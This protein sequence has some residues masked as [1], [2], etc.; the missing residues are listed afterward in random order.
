MT[1]SICPWIFGESFVTKFF[2]FIVF[3]AFPFREDHNDNDSF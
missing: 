2:Y 1:P 3:Y